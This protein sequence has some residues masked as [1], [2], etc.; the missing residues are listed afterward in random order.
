MKPRD[1]LVALGAAALATAGIVFGGGQ[2]L[3]GLSIDSLFWLRHQA[4]GAAHDAASS[5]T[6]VIAIDEETYRT[7]PFADV[8]QALWTPQIGKVLATLVQADVAVVG[9]DL[10]LSTSVERLFRGYDRDYMIALQQAARTNRV[11]LGKVQHSQLPIAP[12]PGFSFAVG[13]QRNIRSTNLITDPD[14]VIRR[15]PLTFEADDRGGGTR[16][17]ASFPLELAMRAAQAQPDWDDNAVRLDGWPIPARDDGMLVNF[18]GGGADIPVYSFADIYACADAGKLDYF[19]AH[20]AG[21]TVLVGVVLDV[22]DRRPTSKR[23]VTGPEGAGNQPRCAIEPMAALQGP[24]VVRDNI[25]GV[26]IHATAVNNMLRREPLRDLGR[27]TDGAIAGGLGIVGATMGVALPLGPAGAVLALGAL[28]YVALATVL[29]HGGLVLPLLPPVATAVLAFV[30]ILAYRIT[31]A[32]KDKRRL[33]QMFGLYLAPEIVDRMVASDH[34]PRLGGERREM[35]FLFTDV[36]GFTSLA[37]RMD[38]GVLAPILNGYLDGACAVIKQSGG[39]V[40][41]FIGDAILAFFGAPQDQPDHAQ[42][43]VDCARALDAY[44][45]AF[46]RRQQADDVPFGRTR[47][48]VHTGAVFVGNVGSDSVKMKYSALGDVVNTASRLEGLN[49]H[50]NT[51]V[52]ISG[53][54]LARCYEDRVRPLGRIILKGRTD[55]IDVFELVE[56]PRCDSAAIARYREAF[57]LLADGDPRA[58][59]AFSALADELPDDGCVALHLE[60]VRAGARD[61]LVVMEEK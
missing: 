56:E 8:P 9:F 47:I 23:F 52:I 51:R 18:E 31:I 2:S 43:A 41:E 55:P 15:V 54:T 21:K 25:P 16:R 3:E 10:I 57:R 39:M 35:S 4:F 20:F 28:G 44:A 40:N 30:L 53:N 50:F 61:T 6:A 12:A 13:N 32:D 36:A 27:P 24:P 45:E 19:R 48:G 38:P 29:F 42:C 17:E 7:P 59:A 46:R 58:E 14:E 49:K 33:R 22:E 11:V 37:E 60:R 5:P 26:F 1:L 34:P